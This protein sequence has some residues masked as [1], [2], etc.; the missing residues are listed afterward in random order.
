[1]SPE[2][3]YI[4]PVKMEISDRKLLRIAPSIFSEYENEDLRFVVLKSRGRRYLLA[5]APA[6]IVE[7]FAQ[8]GLEPPAYVHFAQ[9]ELED[10][11]GCVALPNGGCLVPLEGVWFWIACDGQ[12]CIEAQEF[13]AS[14]TPSSFRAPLATKDVEHQGRLAL[15]LAAAALLV[16]AG[17]GISYYEIKTKTEGF[18]QSVDAKIAAMGL[19]KTL[20]QL[21]SIEGELSS[22]RRANEAVAKLFEALQQAPWADTRVARIVVAKK[23]AVIELHS[24][25]PPQLISYLRSRFKSVH[26]QKQRLEVEL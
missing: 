17:L 20:V 15:Y 16:A 26:T 25:P 13:L 5:Y 9:K 4:K 24:P 10:F 19:P 23:R 22:G 12:K 14:H 7:V 18:E 1:L 6:V 11:E 8:L 3:Y 2:F 21:R